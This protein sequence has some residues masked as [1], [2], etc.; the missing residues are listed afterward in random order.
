MIA[1]RLVSSGLQEYS[2]Q[3]DIS[4]FR[5]KENDLEV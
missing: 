4:C 3:S 1:D 2:S 5:R